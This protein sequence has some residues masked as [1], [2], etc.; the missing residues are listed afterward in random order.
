MSLT[1]FICMCREGVQD[2]CSMCS[3]SNALSTK[4]FQS[5]KLNLAVPLQILSQKKQAYRLPNPKT[6]TSL[7]SHNNARTRRNRPTTLLPPRQTNILPER[8]I[9]RIRISQ[10]S[11]NLR[12]LQPLNPRNLRRRIIN[13]RSAHLPRCDLNKSAPTIGIRSAFISS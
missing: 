13:Q 2:S 4:S 5:S 11:P 6:T 3:C 8:H 10:H 1:S 9:L 7:S 12:T